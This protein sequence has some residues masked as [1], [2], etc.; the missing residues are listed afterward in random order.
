MAEDTK[1]LLQE[2]YGFLEDGNSQAA[3]ACFS[4]AYDLLQKI[5]DQQGALQALVQV[6][7]TYHVNGESEHAKQIARDKM[8]LYQKARNLDG[9]VCMVEQ[10][11]N[12]CLDK[13]D[14]FEAE[15]VAK[16]QLDRLH[17]Y[18]ELGADTTAAEAYMWLS[19]SCAFFGRQELDLATQ[20]AQKASA[21]FA[22]LGLQ[23]QENHA[24]N[25]YNKAIERQGKIRQVECSKHDFYL[26]LRVGGLAYGPRYRNNNIINVGK[27]GNA[28]SAA[29]HLTCDTESWE[30]TV[31]Y[32][33]GILDAGAHGGLAKT[34]ATE[35]SEQPEGPLI[36][37][38][39][40][41]GTFT[42]R[43]MG[44]DGFF[45]MQSGTH[46]FMFSH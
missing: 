9:E 6:V 4:R 40:D 7:S 35:A 29:L 16:A 17:S 31:A 1:A 37:F 41:H 13:Q 5:G 18:I 39:M 2:G 36:P 46:S 3:V 28:C 38:L 12:I 8:L 34:M 33:A 20:A 45:S 24:H 42:R 26:G 32:H 23:E 11:L 30:D 22:S 43:D 10:Y 15:A 27:N 19:L 21:L 14:F 44:R 25:A